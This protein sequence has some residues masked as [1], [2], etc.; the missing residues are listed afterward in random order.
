MCQGDRT[1]VTVSFHTRTT[2][3]AITSAAIIT[4]PAF[5]GSVDT[6]ERSVVD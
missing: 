5:T 3:T 2:T 4:T 6:A 1:V